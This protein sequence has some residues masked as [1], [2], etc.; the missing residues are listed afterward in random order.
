MKAAARLGAPLL[1]AL[2]AAAGC[3]EPP[4]A[5]IGS[6]ITPRASLVLEPPRLQI[7]DVAE[8]E[9]AVVTPPEHRPRPFSPPA[10]LPGLWLL[11]AEALP[12]QK[13]RS[14]W[15][16]RTRL[17]IRAREVGV[18]AWPAGSVEV[19]AP[20]GSVVS[21]GFE[22]LSLE[23]V[24][25][26]AEH[27]ERMTPFG[28]RAPAA[29][30]GA[31]NAVAAAAGALLALVG[32]A[33][34]RVARRRYAARAHALRHPEPAAPAEPPWIEA[35]AALVAARAIAPDDPLA[36]SHAAAA[37]LRRYVARRFRADAV[38][39]TT[40]ELQAATPPFAATSRWPAFV[41]ILRAL[42]E[43]RFRPEPAAAA[44]R[45]AFARRA[46]ELLDSAEGFVEE[47]IP[48]EARG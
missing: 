28:V 36:A 13:E 44:E 39:R 18:F 25:A 48:T 1:T 32:V 26:L 11:D 5:P 22:A 38:A 20:D 34:F 15:V 37:A 6:T 21:L 8:L 12:T 31:P 2:L 4:S 35:R 33:V 47:T 14:R 45:A 7:G 23:V 9:L 27:P 24:S 16:H 30:T 43:R 46:S 40:E 19:E 29:P 10:E 3:G 17:R 41:S 42:D